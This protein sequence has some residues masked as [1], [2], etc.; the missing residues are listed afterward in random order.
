MALV[1]EYKKVDAEL[2]VIWVKKPEKR[3]YINRFQN[4]LPSYATAFRDMFI[5]YNAVKEDK[6]KSDKF[7]KEFFEETLTI[8]KKLKELA[9]KINESNITI[10]IENEEKDLNDWKKN[11]DK[12]KNT[13]NS[14]QYQHQAQASRNYLK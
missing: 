7:V 2:R 10:T 13:F 1:Q 5:A 14:F 12:L 9:I 3:D 4:T 6:N 8:F 11:I